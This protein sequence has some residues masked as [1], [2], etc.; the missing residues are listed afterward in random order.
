MVL[1]E[2][3][4]PEDGRPSPATL[5]DLNMLVMLHGRERTIREYEALLASQGLRVQRVLQT[6]SRFSL[7]EAVR[8]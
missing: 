6:R 2:Q 8:V 7:V 4:V 5:M 1:V 3:I